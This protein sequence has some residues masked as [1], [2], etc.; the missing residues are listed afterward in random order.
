MPVIVVGAD[1]P[2]GEAVI[3]AL[4][5]PGREVRAFVSDPG[6]A[7]RLKK[8]GVKVAL[9]D[10]SDASHLAGAALN[11]FSVVFIE[12]AATDGRDRA[13]AAD[14]A[15]VFEAWAE[16][17]SD[18]SVRRVIWVSSVEPPAGAAP[19]SARVDPGLALDELARRV[20]E[21]DDAVEL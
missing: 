15:A 14:R 7:L 2:A 13:F 12:A 4:L 11:C 10:V 1:T 3:G 5:A 20:A 18:A 19:E 16:A 17:A 6:A 21:L 8:A 9:G